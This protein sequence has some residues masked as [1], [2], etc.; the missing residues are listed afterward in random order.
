LDSALHYY[1]NFFYI[2]IAALK[3]GPPCFIGAVWYFYYDQIGIQD[4]LN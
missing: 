4:H 3:L 2:K 1:F